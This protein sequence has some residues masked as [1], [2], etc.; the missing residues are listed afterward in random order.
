MGKGASETCLRFQ[1]L[2]RGLRT[3]RFGSSC[4]AARLCQLW[5]RGDRKEVRRAKAARGESARDAYLE[6]KVCRRRSRF[7]PQRAN[8]CR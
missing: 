7:C 1:Q 6:R 5:A 4:S 3:R 2:P 8:L